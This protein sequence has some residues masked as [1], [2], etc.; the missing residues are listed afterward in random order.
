MPS[1]ITLAT[2]NAYNLFDSL[3]PHRAK[4]RWQTRALG[5]VVQSMGA[6]IVALQEVES[7]RAL[8]ELNDSVDAPYRFPHRQTVK[9][10]S[11]RDIRVGYVAKHPVRLK[12]HA[13]RVLTDSNGKTI[14]EHPTKRE[15]EAGWLYPLR[16]QRDVALGEFRLSDGI[17]FAVFNLHLK[18]RS[19]YEWMVNAP[20]KIRGAEA[21]EVAT[22]VTAYRSKYPGR[23]F[24]VVGDFNQHH[25][26][27]SLTAL[28]KR[29]DL[30]DPIQ[31]DLVD[32]WDPDLSTYYKNERDRIDYI[33]LSSDDIYEPGSAW[34]YKQKDAYRASDHL[35]LSVDL[36]LS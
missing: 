14:W 8:A 20:N 3:E 5:R 10:N 7:D 21:R 4:P 13:S 29:L 16:F 22:I 24:A 9:G 12:S 27:R 35:A 32:G 28:T 25:E 18:S 30:F 23:P 1:Y 17:V 31:Q 33:L 36:T 11:S 6:D 26:H 19:S 2:Y 34:V 15:F